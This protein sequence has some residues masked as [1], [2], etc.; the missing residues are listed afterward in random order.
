MVAS[1]KKVTQGVSNQFTI[2]IDKKAV[3]VNHCHQNK[4]SSLSPL[5]CLS[6]LFV[7]SHCLL[8]RLHIPGVKIH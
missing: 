3:T 6:P 4:N 5:L 8:S 7:S 1:S 2:D